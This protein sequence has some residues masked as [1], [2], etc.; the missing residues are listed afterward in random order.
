MAVRHPSLS[1]TGLDDI[2]MTPRKYG[3]HATLKPPFRLAEGQDVRSFGSRHLTLLQPRARHMQRL[4]LT[5]LG[6]FLALTPQG[7][8]QAVRRVAGACVRELDRFRAPASEAEL[9]APRKAGL[10]SPQEALLGAMGLS[11]RDGGVSVP[12]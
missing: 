5:T 11:L 6:G 10:S 9:R 1:M 4:A 7:D 3:F 8:M 2:T 12:L